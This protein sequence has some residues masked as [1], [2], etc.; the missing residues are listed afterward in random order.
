M[1]WLNL[2]L[3]SLLVVAPLQMAFAQVGPSHPAMAHADGAAHAANHTEHEHSAITPMQH[4]QA[5]QPCGQHKGPCLACALCGA[6]CSASLMN[7]EFSPVIVH[8]TITITQPLLADILSPPPPGEP[9]R[10]SLV[11]L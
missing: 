4:Q 10:F 5:G 3:A 7:Y 1:K 9:P 6:H 8:S 11:D 2:V